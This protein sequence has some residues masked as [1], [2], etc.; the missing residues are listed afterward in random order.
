MSTVLTVV[1]HNYY[2]VLGLSA[3]FFKK[4]I[5]ALI[6]AFLANLVAFLIFK[7]RESISIASILAFVFW[8]LMTELPLRKTCKVNIKNFLFLTVMCACFYLCTI[9]NIYWLGGIIN[10]GA[11]VGGSILFYGKD[12]K[13]IIKLVKKQ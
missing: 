2:K 6:V 11:F 12:I 9:T 4:S 3:S 1:M 7:S 8:Y 5:I 10:L 13:S